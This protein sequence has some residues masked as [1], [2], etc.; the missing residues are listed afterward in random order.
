MFTFVLADRI[1]TIELAFE[2]KCGNVICKIVK[3]LIL[4]VELNKN[5]NY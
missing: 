5:V 1:T 2:Q 4:I 3:L